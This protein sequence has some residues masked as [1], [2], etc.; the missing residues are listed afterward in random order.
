MNITIYNL[1]LS[2]LKNYPYISISKSFQKTTMNFFSS[3]MNKHISSF[4]Y[5]NIGSSPLFMATF[6][7][8]IFKNFL[9]RPIVLENDNL[10]VNH[11]GLNNLDKPREKLFKPRLQEYNDLDFSSQVFSADFTSLLIKNCHFFLIFV[12]NI[13]G[14]AIF[15]TGPLN[16]TDSTF[17]L[18]SSNHIGTVAIYSDF[19]CNSVFFQSCI[20]SKGSA[21]FSCQPINQKVIINNTCI[22]KCKAH[23]TATLYPFSET[24][25]QMLNSNISY[26]TSIY[27]NSVL[28]F[29]GTGFFKRNNFFSNFGG[30]WCSGI[31]A[32]HLQSFIV[33][34]SIFN[35]L[36]REEQKV[37]GG[38]SILIQDS[39]P[40]MY[41]ENCY[42][43][44][45]NKEYQTMIY[46]GGR[47]I[48]WVIACCFSRSI[49]DEKFDYNSDV[50]KFSGCFYR[51]TCS[52]E[53]FKEPIS[54]IHQRYL[55]R[56]K[57]ISKLRRFIVPFLLIEFLFVFYF[58]FS[59]NHYS[60][61]QKL[62]NKYK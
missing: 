25:F 32:Y 22:E 18:C 16:L 9:D 7:S 34:L 2:S 57:N 42:F 56:E 13:I 19:F 45:D 43:I 28:F 47:D 51:A 5:S 17:H 37:F 4:F 3:R 27:T 15:S 21:I 23:N 41:I 14:S 44:Y 35:N 24:N 26:S 20:T 10:N 53:E 40:I 60:L 39:G 1:V 11:L 36:T 55:V 48:C 38:I 52:L 61:Q 62:S 58:T 31:T 6:Q 30:R 33:E 46:N 54:Q 49:S 12:E 59:H 8:S 29:N 50:L